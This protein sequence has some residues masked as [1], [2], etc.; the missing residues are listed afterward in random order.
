[1]GKQ[2]RFQESNEKNNVPSGYFS[3][4][5]CHKIS[6]GDI[7]RQHRFKR[8]DDISPGPGSYK[9]EIYKTISSSKDISARPFSG[10]ST[11]GTSRAT[12]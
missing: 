7:P 11:F 4:F 1:M 12:N 3:P 8:L 2:Q 5:Y 10:T 9:S 6:Q